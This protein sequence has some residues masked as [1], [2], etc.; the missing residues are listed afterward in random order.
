MLTMHI[1][2]HAY[3]CMHCRIVMT[4]RSIGCRYGKLGMVDCVKDQPLC[5]EQGVQLGNYPHFWVYSRC[6]AAFLPQPEPEPDPGADGGGD[7]EEG[8]DDEGDDDDTEQEE[9]DEAAA[10]K[11]AAEQKE[12]SE[13][14]RD[15][16][17]F[18]PPLS[19]A[20]SCGLSQGRCSAADSEREIRLCAVCD[21]AAG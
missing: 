19:R 10:E 3:I 20:P 6:H 4:N 17:S 13:Q 21:D 11:E 9:D 16:L 15:F 12:V 5:R 14:R 8:A 18:S 2:Y 1:V 7:G